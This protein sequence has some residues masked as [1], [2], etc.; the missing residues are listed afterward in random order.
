M[1][2]TD[3]TVAPTCST[4]SSLGFS[5]SKNTL[6]ES[7]THLF[8]HSQP[9]VLSCITESLFTGYAERLTETVPLKKYSTILES[10]LADIKYCLKTLLLFHIWAKK[11]YSNL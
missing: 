3:R 9:N 6:S 10:F 2:C 1:T 4:A 5:P 7:C 8:S 11:F